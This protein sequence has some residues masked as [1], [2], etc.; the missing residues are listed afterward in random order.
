MVA[1]LNRLYRRH[2]SPL[3]QQVHAI[4]VFVQK[5]GYNVYPCIA[6]LYKSSKGVYGVYIHCMDIV[7]WHRIPD[8]VAVCI[9]CVHILS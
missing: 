5:K 1:G 7:F 9:L 4:Y 2:T 3:A 6:Q 8:I